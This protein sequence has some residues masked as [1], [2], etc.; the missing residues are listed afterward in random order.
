MYSGVTEII[1]WHGECAMCGAE[2]TGDDQEYY[3]VDDFVEDYFPLVGV[4]V[5][6]EYY[7]LLCYR[8]SED[9]VECGW[10]ENGEYFTYDY[11]SWCEYTQNWIPESHETCWDEAHEHLEPEDFEMRDG[12]MC[13]FE[14]GWERSTYVLTNH[15]KPKIKLG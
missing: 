9:V 15:Q 12:R 14:C 10:C 13:C 4:E 8:C 7:D 11:G 1:A 3:N 2:Y 5:D 6:D